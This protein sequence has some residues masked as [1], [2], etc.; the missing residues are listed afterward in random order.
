M[1]VCF[2]SQG[3]NLNSEIDSRF[4]RCQY[5]V[6]VDTKTKQLNSIQ[7]PH[8]SAGSGAGI[9]SGQLVAN[10]KIKAVLTGNIRI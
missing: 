2:S 5:F 3:D 9:Q 6:F 4:R 10:Q 8:R 1:K 7:N